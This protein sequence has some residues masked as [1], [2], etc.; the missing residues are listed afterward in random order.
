MNILVSGCL[1]GLNCKY[2]GNNNLVEEIRALK[3]KYNLIPVC[4]EQ[5]GGLATPRDPA[6][7]IVVGEDIKVITKNG[8]DVTRGY[9]QGA[10]ET[11]KLAKMFNCQVA[12]LKQRSP[13]CGNGK[14]YDGTFSSKLINGD[15]ITAK[16]LKEN[17]IKI[18]SEDELE[19]L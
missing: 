4:P 19:K 6:E 18:S 12:I 5:L 10:I 7:I 17:G 11:L 14:I 3:D 16:L 8:I 2:S 15:G 13:S 1:L 9:A